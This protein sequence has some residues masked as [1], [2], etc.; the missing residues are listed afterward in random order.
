MRAATIGNPASVQVQ[1]RPTPSGSLFGYTQNFTYNSTN[2]L[3]TASEGSTTWS[4][5]FGYDNWGNM[6]GTQSG[7]TGV[8]PLPA[9]G[10]YD[11][12]TNRRNSSSGVSSYD[13]AGNQLAFGASVSY[14]AENRVTGAT[15]TASNTY[16]YGFDGLGE[17]VSVVQ[18][19]GTATTLWAVSYT[20]LTLP[21]NRE[22]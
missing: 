7:L 22:V 11:T 18:N 1:T 14:D 20:H 3:A 21:T 12:T 16:Q 13:L 8:T 4:Q 10:T 19:S 9:S 2:Q 5:N 6:S 17:R 15:D